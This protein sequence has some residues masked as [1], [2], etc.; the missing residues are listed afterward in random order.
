MDHPSLH[1]II[2]LLP[3]ILSQTP[4]FL[5]QN[6]G[7]RS[8]QAFFFSDILLTKTAFRLSSRLQINFSRKKYVSLFKALVDESEKNKAAQEI[9][10]TRIYV[11]KLWMWTQ[12][13]QTLPNWDVTFPHWAHPALHCWSTCLPPPCCTTTHFGP[14]VHQSIT[15]T[16]LP[17]LQWIVQ[18]LC[19]CI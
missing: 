5:P 2:Q 1:A 13:G 8:P 9:S 16:R 14:I 4:T 15:E 12:R 11:H 10:S 3:A 18:C 6:L 19:L 17:A 7:M